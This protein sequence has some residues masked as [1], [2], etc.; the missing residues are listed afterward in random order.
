MTKRHFGELLRTRW[1]EGKFA[2]VG[3]DTEYERAR[4]ATG[5]FDVAEAMVA[6]NIAIVEAT[7]DLVCAFKPNSAFYEAYGVEGWKILDATIK[8]IKQIAPEVPVILDAK[9][10]DI[11]NTNEAY[12]RSAFELLR[13][14][15]ITVS[16][17]LGGGSLAPFLRRG[18]KG[19]FVL[20]HTSN[21]EA[22][23]IQH[24]MTRRTE[25]FYELWEII[26]G[27]VA[28]TWNTDGNC[29]LVIGGKAA[30]VIARA[31]VIAPELPFLIP[32]IGAQGGDLEATVK[33]AGT[34]FIINSSRSTIY[35]AT[36]ADFASAA[37]RA[38]ETLHQQITKHL[39]A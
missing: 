23:E 34:K 19:V 16:P 14:D 27:K 33:A 10:G 18:D 1:S 15:A 20:C 37:R 39:V 36:G 28:D 25:N 21:P 38:T 4:T 31:R 11:G 22:E 2:C 30:E 32:G 8:A 13:A 6:F 3:L 17:Y 9:R 29:G 12:A 35:A 26:A 5:K 7:H 24:L